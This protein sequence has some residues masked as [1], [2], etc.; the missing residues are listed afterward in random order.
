[1][2]KLFS[3]ILVLFLCFMLLPVSV[4]AETMDVYVSSTGSDENSGTAEAPFATLTK[5]IEAVPDHG[6][7][8]VVGTVVV[9]DNF[10][11][12]ARGQSITITGDTLDLTAVAYMTLGD[13]VTFRNITLNGPT[14]DGSEV[15]IYANGYKMV[16]DTGITTS[17]KIE[18]LGGGRWKTV[19]STDLTVLSG[20]YKVIYGGGNGSNTATGGASRVRGDVNLYIGGTTNSAADPTSH[21]FDN[22]YLIFGGGRYDS[23]VDGKVNLTFTG[24][25]KANY[26]FGGG[27]CYQDTATGT[28]YENATIAGGV[29]MVVSGNVKT[30]DVTGGG[31]YSGHNGGVELIVTG[32][33]MEQIFGGTQGASEMGDVTVSVFGGKVTRRVFG[34]C[35]NECSTFGSYETSYHVEGNIRLIIGGGAN[36]AFTYGN[37]MGIYARSRQKTVSDTG[38]SELIFADNQGY[39]NH[40]NKLGAQSSW[41]TT[42]MGSVTAADDIHYF[43]YT[44][45]G[46][47]LTGKCIYEDGCEVTP[48]ATLE[49]DSSASLGYTGKAITPAKVTTTNWYGE[50]PEITYVNNIE[51]GASA[52]ASIT[53]NGATASLNFAIE[54][55]YFRSLSL[56]ETIGINFKATRSFLET[57][58]LQKVEFY[59]DGSLVQTVTGIPAG[60]ADRVSFRFIQLTPAQMG[61]EV[62]ARFCFADGTYDERS[63][64]V[65]AYALSML[66]KDTTG[67]KLKTLLVDMIH[68]GAATQTYVGDTGTLVSAGD[69]A[70]LGTTADPELVN[71]TVLSNAPETELVT[72]L[73]AGLNLKDSVTLRLKFSADSIEGLTLKVTCDGN[74]WEITDFRT[75]SGGYYVFF[76][77]LNPAQLR[78]KIEAVF[79]DVNGNQVSKMLTYSIVSYAYTVA[80]GND[81][82]LKPLTTALIRYGDAVADWVGEEYVASVTADGKTTYYET[83]E[84]AITYANAATT[85][86][87]ITLFKDVTLS[88]TPDLTNDIT[89]VNA[90][91]Q[92][93]T[94]SRG[95]D[96]FNMFRVYGGGSLTLGTNDTNWGGTLTVDGTSASP[97]GYRIVR[98]AGGTTFTLGK[99][100]TLTNG[101]G[102]A[103]GGAVYTAGTANIYGTI[104]GNTSTA[105]GGGLYVDATGTANIYGTI[106]GNE[107]TK[108]GGGVYVLGTAEIYGS[109]SNNASSD[110]G[111]GLCVADGANVTS[112]GATFSENDSTGNDKNAGA[113]YVA[114]GGTYTDTGS[115]YTGN[116][117]RNG[118]AIFL[119][120]DGASVTLSGAGTFTNNAAVTANGGAIYVN[121]G[122]LTLNGYTFE[123]NAAKTNADSAIHVAKGAATIEGITFQGGTEQKLYVVTSLT[124]ADLTDVTV[125]QAN[126]GATLTLSGDAGTN[127]QLKPYSY[128]DDTVVI[129][130]ESSMDLSTVAVAPVGDGSYWI[131]DENGVLQNY[132]VASIGE[133]NY[134]TLTEALAAAKDSGAAA[135]IVMLRSVTLVEAVE[136]TTD[137]TIINATGE[138][139]A[140]SRGD[141]TADMFTVAEGG[142]LTLGTNDAAETGKLILDGASEATIEYRTVTVNSGATF[143][144]GKNA[145]LQNANASV[146]GGALYT[147]SANTYVYGTI[148]NNAGSKGAGMYVVADA[149]AAEGEMV[150]I[151]GASFISN[152]SSTTGGAIQIDANA[153]VNSTNTLFADNKALSATG[154][155][156]NGGAI[157][158]AGTFTDTNSIYT[159]NEARNG[160][161]IFL[162]ASTANVELTGT[163][164]TKALFSGNAAVTANGGAIFV[165][166]GTLQV[167]GYTFEGNTAKTNANGAIHITNGSATVENAVFQGASAQ[168]IYVNSALTFQNLS[169]TQ[170]VEM[171]SAA[172]ITLSGD[173]GTNVQLTPYTYTIGQVVIGGTDVDFSTIA[174]TPEGETSWCIDADGALQHTAAIITG[175]TPHYYASLNAAL[176]AAET[177]AT[178]EL[179]VAITL[180]ETITIDKAVTI[181]N[182]SGKEI[183]ITRGSDLTAD[184]FTVAEGGSLTLGTSD[185]AETGKLILDGA[186]DSAVAGRT[187]TVNSGATF[188]LNK[189]ATLRNAN[190]TAEGGALNT[191]GMTYLYGSISNN[192]GKNG[193]G[194]NVQATATVTCYEATFSGN[195]SVS[196]TN[197]GAIYVAGTFTDTNSTYSGNKAKNG[198]AIFLGTSTANVEL[199]GTDPTKALFSGNIATGDTS[200]RGGAIFVNSGGTLKVSGYTFE[201]NTST[202]TKE[203]MGEGAIHVVNGSATVEDIVFRGDSAQKIYVNKTLIFRELTGAQIVQA[204][205]GAT[206]TLSGDAG[207][208]VQLKPYTYTIGQVVIG[209]TDVDFST[210]A[211]TPEGET[212][213]CIDADGALQH[214]AAIITG[215]TPHYYASLNAALA[216]AETG[217]TIE[218]PVAITLTETITIDKAVTIVNASGKE[219]TITRGSDLTADLFTVAEGG[220]LTLGTSDAAETGKLILDGASDSAVAGRTV[221]VN[222]GATFTLNKNATLCNANSK[223]SGGALH[224]AGTAYLYGT[225]SGNKSEATGAG[226]Y[227][228][229]GA[230]VNSSGATFSNNDSTGNTQ[231]GGAVYVYKNA[232]FTDNGSTYTGNKAKNGAAIFTGASGANVEI[233]NANFTSNQVTANGSAIYINYGTLT[234]GNS[235]FTGNTKTDGTTV[236]TIYRANRAEASMVNKG[237]VMVDGESYT[238]YMTSE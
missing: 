15:R 40:A 8:H 199:I 22:G 215:D 164:T 62:T 6:T 16:M 31:F 184:L 51:E 195:Q 165:N 87:Q 182:A 35:Y 208:N 104:T 85:K 235:T 134:Y 186:S 154:T 128:T 38:V 194:L 93:I 160:G 113:V 233:E 127:V 9:P 46:A 69:Y 187:V 119:A 64:S 29:H 230:T 129:T 124:F 122:T 193:A 74:I 89:I 202:G 167:N 191:A 166:G 216:A 142:S 79:Y 224:V 237:G 150:Q 76:S 42:F 125:V 189:N 88:E 34:G 140:I 45:D 214:T 28:V 218:L 32:G 159:G 149:N 131:I 13:A 11:C 161:A 133:T 222:S 183:T 72:W 24:N 220:S 7:I 58:K 147:A 155:Y 55:V 41:M 101:T 70:G 50:T 120:G 148:C 43:Q 39:T 99:N 139:I 228:A 126:A 204:A 17:G 57:R 207:T 19:A 130:A 138:T 234:I 123:G 221:T 81:E 137:V 95:A 229:S 10:N 53:V 144:L 96:N 190:S 115:N 238:Q 92:E 206:I 168:K 109:I 90:S 157:Y 114:A 145:V 82:T 178:I 12:A 78:D 227:V 135:Q 177:G 236:T 36:F 219:I 71:H 232:T 47:T 213:W 61:K 5:A 73:S 21:S 201:S 181:V 175:D 176:A 102:T 171:K 192:K 106:S 143:T 141:L 205:S 197:G 33:E 27:R 169:G 30:M 83:I 121:G 108:N 226:L 132:P 77:G 105:N 151:D 111:A 103:I 1:M 66:G 153:K 56:G 231:N 217:A 26:V 67:T 86:A 52:T 146:V 180:T 188:T 3:A 158:V 210:I 185:A 91:G 116:K 172:T 179:P 223:Q 49:L 60:N 163:D 25:A 198:G 170:I 152:Q 75:T 107:S 203:N 65:E 173:A 14:A 54:P 63:T 18:L 156:A 225:I 97:I 94:I 44:A 112:S 4:S 2:K 48:T 20:S 59:M 174:V 200:S 118:G 209:G 196:I 98:V 110:A 100:A 162:G 68:Y 23:P 37:D 136:I 117:A 211:V 84:D 212:S 80:K